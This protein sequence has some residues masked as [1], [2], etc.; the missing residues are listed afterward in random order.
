MNAQQPKIFLGWDPRETTGFAVACNSL[1]RTAGVPTLP[2]TKVSLS[3][4]Q[5]V[6]LYRRPT[7][8]RGHRLYDLLSARDNYDGAIS[9]EHAIARFFVPKLAKTGW[10][11]FA[12]GSD[13]L[14]RHDIADVFKGLD[15][16]MA[17]YCVHHVHEPK[18]SRKMDDQVQTRYYRKNWSSFMIFNCDH[19]LNKDLTQ[20]MLNSVP[21][22]LL[23]AFG[24]LPSECI[25]KL[26]PAWNHLVGYSDPLEDPFVAHFTSGTP[27]M[28]GHKNDR[29]A[30][31]WRKEARAVTRGH[32]VWEPH[33]LGAV[34]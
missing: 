6:G 21:G 29:F 19:E 3:G 27:D 10:A 9:T 13:M 33:T 2:I 28:P 23:H 7:E 5:D 15:P 30:D 16:A 11:L 4:L 26:N 25:G 20:E 22:R 1:R 12:D 8:Q 32:R 14:F 18:D 34:L 31:E 24:W 17:V